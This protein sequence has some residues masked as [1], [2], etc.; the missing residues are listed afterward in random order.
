MTPQERLE[1]HVDRLNEGARTG[2]FEAYSELFAADGTLKLL[3]TGRSPATKAEG[4]QAIARACAEVF[5][6]QQVRVA[7][8]IAATD[9]SATFDYAWVSA[10]KDVAGQMIVKWQGDELTCVTV[11]V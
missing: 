9:A 3:G 4:R 1:H 5:D 11:T 7:T 6:G 10:P 2:R 8:V